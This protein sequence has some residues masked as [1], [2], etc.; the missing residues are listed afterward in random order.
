MPSRTRAGSFR[1]Q[2]SLRPQSTE[3]RHGIAASPGIAV[4][5]PLSLTAAASKFP[6]ATSQREEVPELVR[7]DEAVSRADWQL[8]RMSA[9]C[10]RPT[11]SRPWSSLRPISSSPRRKHMINPTRRRIRDEKDQMPSGAVQDR[12]R[13]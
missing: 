2:A 6:S 4:G 13:D 1:G 3:L 12:R 5:A 10:V 7:L 11:K 8:E 9:S